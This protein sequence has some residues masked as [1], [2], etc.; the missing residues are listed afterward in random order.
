M[1]LKNF[2]VFFLKVV[3]DASSRLTIFGAWMYT[4]NSGEFSTKMTVAFYYAMVAILFLKNLVFSYHD[5][6]GYLLT[7]GALPGKILSFT[8]PCLVISIFFHEH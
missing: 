8:S 2:F 7:N 6:I 5:K 3:C 4:V 1:D